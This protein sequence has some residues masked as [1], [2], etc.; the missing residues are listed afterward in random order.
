M[1]PEVAMKMLMI[2]RVFYNYVTEVADKK[3]L[4]MKLGLAKNKA[5]LEEIM[6][7]CPNL[8]PQSP[9]TSAES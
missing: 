5:A 9:A 4:T 3:A 6:E 2:F 8:S 1:H 7:F